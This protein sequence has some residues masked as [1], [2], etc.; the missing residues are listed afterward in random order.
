[1]EEN[2]EENY[3]VQQNLYPSGNEIYMDDCWAITTEPSLTLPLHWIDLILSIFQV[4]IWLVPKGPTD[5]QTHR[6]ANGLTYNL[7][8]AYNL[9]V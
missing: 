7:K 9:K 2:G 3:L 1:M 8:L 4:Q 6:Q 5:G